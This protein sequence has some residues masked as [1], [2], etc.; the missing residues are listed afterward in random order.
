MIDLSVFT[1]SKQSKYAAL[2]ILLAVIALSLNILF[3][4]DNIPFGQ[5]LG[6]IF[7]LLLVS[8]P[9]FLLSLMQLTCIVSGN[10]LKNK[11][12][13]C[14]WYSWILSAILIIYSIF[15]IV[16]SIIS[17]TQKKILKNQEYFDD[18]TTSNQSNPL[19]DL[20]CGQ[21]ATDLYMSGLYAQELC[22]KTF[23]PRATNDDQQKCGN[24]IKTTLIKKDA[25]NTNCGT[26]INFF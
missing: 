24:A 3:S 17:L 8:L 4:Q 1:G 25:L 23:G 12:F 19:Q 9:G 10:G 2:F 11:N 14:G 13:W 15:I 20:A 18:T 5:K 6:F 26:N 16:F 21:A 22:T 7:L